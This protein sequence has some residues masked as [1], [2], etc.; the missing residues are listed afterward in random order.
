M[1]TAI[2]HEAALTWLNAA[3]GLDV[4]VSVLWTHGRL[5]SEAL[6]MAGRLCHVEAEHPHRAA[7]TYIVS[8][9][10]M[11]DLVELLDEDWPATAR[12]DHDGTQLT[13]EQGPVRIEIAASPRGMFATE[14]E[15]ESE[16]GISRCAGANCYESARRRDGARISTELLSHLKKVG[17]GVRHHNRGAGRDRAPHP[18]PPRERAR[19]AIRKLSGK[20]P[21]L[22]GRIG[23]LERAFHD[24]EGDV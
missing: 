12:S 18:E 23:D 2:S 22:K 24:E 13:I 7:G 11:L 20:R 14:V 10:G 6:H 21:D 3:V 9:G 19:E 4:S 16:V 17:R 1:A 5:E 8:G 15:D